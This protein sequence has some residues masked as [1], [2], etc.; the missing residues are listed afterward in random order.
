MREGFLDQETVAIVTPPAVTMEIDIQMTSLKMSNLSDESG[1]VSGEL[2]DDS[3]L[4][5][6][7]H[8]GLGGGPWRERRE[9]G[10]GVK[11]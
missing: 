7:L 5:L 4:I 11:N 6:H 8:L 10:G 1:V 9:R 2:V 3:S